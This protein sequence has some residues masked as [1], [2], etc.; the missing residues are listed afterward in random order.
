M[1][2]VDLDPPRFQPP[3][4]V[5]GDDGSRRTVLYGEYTVFSVFQPV[6]C[7]HH[8]PDAGEPRCSRALVPR[9]GM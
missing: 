7:V 1:S 9:A 3:R 5:A 2:M 8:A 4:P 6:F